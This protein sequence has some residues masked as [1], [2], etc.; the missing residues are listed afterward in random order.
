M[1]KRLCSSSNEGCSS[2]ISNNGL[3]E[4]AKLHSSK[5]STDYKV[6]PVIEIKNK[7]V[8]AVFCRSS[9]VVSDF[10][11]ESIQGNNNQVTPTASLL[12]DVSSLSSSIIFS[13]N[14]LSFSSDDELNLD[15]EELEHQVACNFQRYAINSPMS[16]EHVQAVL[17]IFKPI[18][19]SLPESYKT[20]INTEYIEI[21]K[22]EPLG[23]EASF[24]Y[25]EICHQINNII[26]PDLYSDQSELE[27]QVNCNGMPLSEHSVYEFWPI[28]GCI[29][30][31][32]VY[33]PF[34]IAVYIGKGRPS[35]LDLFVKKFVDEL[36]DVLETGVELGGKKFVVKFKGFVCNI[37]A[38]CFLKNIKD[39][40]S[41]YSCERCI[42]CGHRSISGCTF[43]PYLYAERR[44]NESFRAKKHEAHHEG[45]TPL[46]RLT[47]KVD[48]VK[49][50]VLD[51]MHLVY[52]GTM[53]RLLTDF[54]SKPG[55]E[56]SKAKVE[57]LTTRLKNLSSQIPQEFQGSTKSNDD[58]SKWK[59]MDFRF[60][61]LYSGPFVLQDILPSQQFRHFMLLHASMRIFNS[62]KLFRKYIDF[63]QLYLKRF[64]LAAPLIYGNSSQDMN[65]HLLGHLVDDVRRFDCTL[66]EISAFRFE[67]LLGTLKK[68]LKPGFKP[69]QQLRRCVKQMQ[70]LNDNKPNIEF[71]KLVEILSFIDRDKENYLKIEKLKY[72]QFT[73]TSEPPNNV[74]LL[75]DGRIVFI[76]K[77]FTTNENFTV[78]EI[79]VQG[80]IVELEGPAF[81]FPTNSSIFNVH[82][83]KKIIRDCEFLLM[84][85]EN[86][87]LILNMYE[88]KSEKAIFPDVYVLPFLYDDG[89]EAL[90]TDYAD[91][92]E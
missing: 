81:T 65:L 35:N 87:M 51:V 68:W 70:L 72:R 27:I 10:N 12:E 32:H 14:E 43:F 8:P 79:Q 57:I 13:T 39:H 60:F 50:F 46:F 18:C 44:T 45:D 6:F 71:P 23:E 52:L 84:N 11:K 63:A 5:P 17:K 7:I 31:K 2:E 64:F 48:L 25:F 89:F 33:K 3:E 67:V 42:I 53:K 62:R 92:D 80:K 16:K 19:P 28:F 37:P 24:V 47:D 58:I 85:I 1:G 49:D 66:D 15:Q 73:L 76:K 9:L 77:M 83:V 75:K 4:F 20:F 61:L 55:E 34:V 69:M 40:T 90:F 54:W 30:F 29:F 36:N 88:E 82:K 41:F 56:L 21:F 38:R 22:I 91:L 59:A 26:N 74:V 86:K 78:E